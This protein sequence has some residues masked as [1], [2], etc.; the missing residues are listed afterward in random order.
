MSYTY[1]AL[2]N[3]T[4]RTDAEGNLTRWT[5]SGKQL[6]SEKMY[7]PDDSFVTS[8]RFV[9]DNEGHLRFTVSAEGR[10]TENVYYSN[11]HAH[12]G[13]LFQTIVYSDGYYSGSS[14]NE[15]SL[16]AWA[17]TQNSH[18]LRLSEY[19]YDALGQLSQTVHYA[20]SVRDSSGEV[21]GV[22]TSAAEN[23]YYTYDRYGQLVQSIVDKGSEVIETS[24][25]YDGMGRLLASTHQ[26]GFD[27]VTRTGGEIITVSQTS[28]VEN[29]IQKTEGFQNISDGKIPL[30]TVTVSD[31]AGRIKGV[32][33][34]AD[35]GWANAVA[36]G[37]A[38]DTSKNFERSTNHEYNAAGQLWHSYG[39][40]G[41]ESFFFYDAK[42][43]LVATVKSLGNNEGRVTQTF[44]NRHGEVAKKNDIRKTRQ[45]WSMERRN[46]A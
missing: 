3:R 42:G 6:L 45:S 24:Y 10:V 33:S 22:V 23:N 41:T 9:Y 30:T 15:S 40:D 43:R 17:A 11:H 2:G 14:L 12:D 38:V 19:R 26:K 8:K 36:N 18:G 7:H 21:S 44:Y 34:G 5:Y 1:D 29:Q 28:Y 27:T 25:A 4:S 20:E 35:A 46:T 39:S 31:S 32:F 16:A 37:K 13:L